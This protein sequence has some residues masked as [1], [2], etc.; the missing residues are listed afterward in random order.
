MNYEHGLTRLKEYLAK[1]APDILNDFSTLEDRFHKNLRA[2]RIFGSSENTRAEH[3]QIIYALNQLGLEHCAI[4]F[5]DLCQDAPLIEQQITESSD[6]ALEQ[7]KM[8]SRGNKMKPAGEKYIEWSEANTMNPETFIEQEDVPGLT[9][10]LIKF[11]T[12]IHEAGDRQD[13]LSGA[14]IDSTFISGVKCGTI[15]VIFANSLLARFREYRPSSKQLDYH[16]MIT[17]FDFLLN[18]GPGNYGLEDDHVILCTRLIARGKE[19]FK[20]LITRSAVGRIEAPQENGI[21]TGVLVESDLLLTCR[22]VF[23]NVQQAWVRFGYKEGSYG[24]E[25]VFELDIKNFVSTHNQNQLDYA[26]VRIKGQP[27]PKPIKPV[28]KVL[29]SGA[30]T[31]IRIIHHPQGQSVVISGPGQIIR[32]GEDYIDHDLSTDKGS[33]G[34]PIFDQDWELIAIHRGDTRMGRTP[35]PNTTEGLPIYAIWG[36]ISP[37]LT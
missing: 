11:A 27:K 3:S 36:R 2:E 12:K 5:N 9:A 4:S 14:G 26:L 10:A 8:A 30:E 19:N 13:I 7:A 31:Q 1:S 34:A 35:P 28:N 20:A 18:T 23:G 33:S 29:S 22:H 24:L 21:G 6:D 37:H 32:V 25:D 16:P 15:P 17:F